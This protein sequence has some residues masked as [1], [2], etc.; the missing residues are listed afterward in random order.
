[1][2]ILVVYSHPVEESFCA[3]MRD[4][5]VSALREAGHEVRLVDLYAEGFSPVL[6][7]QE[8]LDYHDEDR[9]TLNVK[10]HIDHILWAEGLVFIFPTWWY[11]MPA[12]LTGWF[13]R[14]W[15]PYVTFG[16]PEGIMPIKPGMTH[17]RFVAG[18][19]SCGSP[20]WWMKLV[21][22]PHWRILMRGLRPL[23]ARRCKTLW[24][25]LHQMDSQTDDR[26]K[27]HL[28]KIHDKLLKIR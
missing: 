28:A 12:M 6:T 20:W 22:T 16:M 24:M 21:G 8:R 9:N 23:F 2:R 14:V 7:R 15:V 18:L 19:T 25:C 27:A 3:A 13:E 1:M 5:A 10:T 11:D 26:R 17:I 4:T